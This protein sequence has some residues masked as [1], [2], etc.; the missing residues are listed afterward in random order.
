MD[1]LSKPVHKPLLL[2]VDLSSVRL[3]DWTPI[4]PAPYR[5]L[6]TTSSLHSAMECPCETANHPSMTAEIQELLSRAVL[7]TSSPIPRH[8]TPMRSTSVAL[9]TPPM[10]GAEDSLGL[11]RVDLAAPK[12]RATSLQASLW[13][14]MANDAI[15]I[16]HLPS[17]T[18]ASETPKVASV[19][20]APQSKTHLGAN[21]GALPDE[22]LPLQG[23]MN[24][25]MGWILTTRASMDT[26]YRR[27]VSNTQTAFCQTRPGLLRP[28]RRQRLIMQA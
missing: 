25:A 1:T 19:P 5:A 11:K 17:P 4:T 18:P 15:P 26:C 21:S 23:K 16:S 12:Q 13:A 3:R 14:D 8:T 7:N 2:Q 6:Y 20:T 10:N 22:V 9:G 24:M 28:L 27:L